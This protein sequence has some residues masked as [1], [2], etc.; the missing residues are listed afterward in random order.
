[1]AGKA[2]L[3]SRLLVVLVAATAWISLIVGRTLTREPFVDE[4]WLALPAWNLAMNHSMGTP[5][6][7]TAGSPM[8]G[9]RISLEGLRGHTY[10]VM[11][12]PTLML[13]GWY[14]V[15]GFSLLTTR[16][17]TTIWMVILLLAWYSILKRLSGDGYVS[18]IGVLLIATDS[19]M[20]SRASFGRMDIMSAALGFSGVASY[21]NL[22]AKSLA[23]AVLAGQTLVVLAGMSHPNGGIVGFCSL[24]SLM[25][26]LDRSR[27]GWRH[28]GVAAVPYVAGMVGMG[29]YI[30]QDT[31]AFTAQFFSHCKGRMDGLWSPLSAMRGEPGRY[32]DT[33]GLGSS[34]QGVG[35]LKV[36]VLVAYVSSVVWVCFNRTARRQYRCLLLL[37]GVSMAALALFESLKTNHYLVYILPMFGALVAVAA[38]GASALRYRWLAAGAITALVCLQ[39]AGFLRLVIYRN[40][41]R[42]DYAP[43]VRWVQNTSPPGALIVADAAFFFDLGT[44]QL[45]DDIRVGYLTGKKPGL[46]IW[47][48]RYRDSA[49]HLQSKEPGAWRHVHNY[50]NNEC[51]ATLLHHSYTVYVCR[52]RK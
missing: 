41:F 40:S 2:K 1:M 44:S 42:D 10:W 49:K 15:T 11:P 7:E 26:L 24:L 6:L 36:L 21:L 27:L 3:K 16:L 29:L 13:A 35:R 18:A 39:I 47:N 46:V 33:F 25:V 43:V 12:L 28:I 48:E 38:F 17:F 50:L 8:P 20:L 5:V 32:A 45:L 34:I 37:A 30:L 52:T 14:K 51:Q 22:R 23:A 9:M 31:S 4:A 19:F